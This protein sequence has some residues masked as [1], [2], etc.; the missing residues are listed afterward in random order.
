MGKRGLRSEPETRTMREKSGLESLKF[1]LLEG[2]TV[3]GE[4]D[5]DGEAED[6][7]SRHDALGVRAEQTV[8]QLDASL[9]LTHQT[10]LQRPT[11]LSAQHST[12]MRRKRS[13]HATSAC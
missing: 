11:L 6:V 13:Q 2:L 3:E 1:R 7:A 9:R 12:D 10:R 5:E 8:R 4:D